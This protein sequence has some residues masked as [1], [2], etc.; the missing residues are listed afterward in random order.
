MLD[1]YSSKLSRSPKTRK[2]EAVTAQRSLMSYTI[3]WNVAFSMSYW[4]KKK[5]KSED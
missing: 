4:D 1:H 5:G 2:L 3:T